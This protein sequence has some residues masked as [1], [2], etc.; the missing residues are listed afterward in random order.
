PVGCTR[1]GTSPLRRVGRPPTS[2]SESPTPS[3]GTS[4]SNATACARSSQLPINDALVTMPSRCASS[5]RRSDEGDAPKSSAVTTR[6]IMTGLPS[7]LPR[8]PSTLTP[9]DASAI[10]IRRR[11]QEKRERAHQGT[12]A[13]RSIRGLLD[14]HLESPVGRAGAAKGSGGG[15]R[16]GPGAV[17]DRHDLLPEGRR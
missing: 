10:A 2:A 4:F 3:P 17:R 5:V 11:G 13:P 1:L 9:E 16:G 14:S 15:G 12:E 8:A 7:P 6:R